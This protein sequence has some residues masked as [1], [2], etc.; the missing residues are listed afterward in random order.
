MI[1][2]ETKVWVH[3]NASE[4][5]AEYATSMLKHGMDPKLVKVGTQIQLKSLQF[6]VE[7]ATKSGIP[8]DK[9]MQVGGWELK[10]GMPRVEGQLPVLYHAMPLW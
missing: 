7:S 5:I 8:Y 4:H 2:G 3:G 1:A 9:L 10:F 6:A